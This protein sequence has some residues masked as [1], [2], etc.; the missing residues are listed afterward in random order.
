MWEEISKKRMSTNLKERMQI[1]ECWE[2]L[3]LH[4]VS[5][6]MRVVAGTENRKKQPLA[7]HIFMPHYPAT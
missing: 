5:K 7:S 6:K 1:D 3:R 2:G 4:Q